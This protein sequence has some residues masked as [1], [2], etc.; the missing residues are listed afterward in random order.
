MTEAPLDEAAKLRVRDA[1]V[2]SI[3]SRL[4]GSE[5][6]TGAE[7]RAAELDP[8]SAYSIDDQFQSDED[9]ELVG[10]LEKADDQQQAL[11]DEIAG[12]DFGGKDAVGPGAVISFG[13]TSY[14]V[15]VAAEP[16]A[17]DGVDYQAVSTNAPIYRAI[18]GLRAGDT[19]T[20]ATSSRPSIR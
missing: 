14:V 19:F 17:C 7:H 2:A 12:I 16:F 18:D 6:D 3:R 11:L 4:S 20:S 8:D 1:L 15:G 13:G 10:Q 5:Q 9:A